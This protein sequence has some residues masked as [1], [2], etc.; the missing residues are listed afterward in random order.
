MRVEEVSFKVK[1]DMPLSTLSGKYSGTRISKWSLLRRDLIH[2]S[3]G[4]KGAF[5]ELMEIYVPQGAIIATSI[6]TVSGNTLITECRCIADKDILVLIEDNNHMALNPVVFQDGWAHYRLISFDMERLKKL[7][8][9]IN[10]I[11]Q[12][13][14][15]GRKGVALDTRAQIWVDTFFGGLT[16]KQMDSLIK[17]HENKYY[18]FPRGVRTDSIA[19]SMG[20][21]RQTYEQHLRK[22]ESKIIEAVI[23]FLK[24]YRS[25]ISPSTDYSFDERQEE[26]LSPPIYSALAQH[27]MKGMDLPNAFKYH[28][29]Q[30]DVW[31]QS[32]N[33]SESVQTLEACLEILHEG[34]SDLKID[35]VRDLEGDIYWRLARVSAFVDDEN[36]ISYAQKALEIFQ[37]TGNDQRIIDIST[38]VVV[39]TKDPEY[40]HNLVKKIPDS[41]DNIGSKAHF[42]CHYAKAINDHFGEYDKAYAVAKKNM[43]RVKRYGLDFLLTEMKY[44]MSNVMPINSGED[45]KQ[46]FDGL[47][48]TVELAEAR[49]KVDVQAM[50]ARLVPEDVISFLGECYFWLKYDTGKANQQLERAINLSTEHQGLLDADI[51]RAMRNYMVTLHT[52]GSEAAAV[53]SERS[54]TESSSYSVGHNLDILLAFSRAV[55]A[56]YHVVNGE[57]EKAMVEIR[58][59]RDIGRDNFRILYQLPSVLMHIELC[60]NKDAELELM[61]A[62]EFLDSKPLQANTVMYSV[63]MNLFSTEN[64]VKMGKLT[65]AGKKAARLRDIEGIMEEDWIRA[66]RLR[67]EALIIQAKGDYS[68]AV[69]L[70]EK[71]SSI[72]GNLGVEFWQGRDLLSLGTALIEQKELPGATFNLNRA[73]ELF[74]HHGALFF[75]EKALSGRG[76]LEV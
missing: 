19:M 13:E 67:A 69:K 66:C 22:A 8:A 3:P 61:E 73:A 51:N 33:F 27:Y 46:I 41:I 6:D 65:E 37:K 63:F 70:L 31:T 49:F 24:M 59:I 14:L 15:Q 28:S 56:W 47:I 50:D 23:P 26:M 48:E 38:I 36:V 20:M 21:S 1:S 5:D 18:G 45:K 4:D 25:G 32:Y 72:W 11:G 12:V 10:D 75:V 44:L 29:K 35:S 54:L 9:E 2:F 68:S 30:A 52:E 42:Y 16:V 57:K 62:M 55:L 60:E 64:S 34:E 53:Y 7:F 17:A 71:S 74:S 76:L 40:Y 39:K 58:K 43:E